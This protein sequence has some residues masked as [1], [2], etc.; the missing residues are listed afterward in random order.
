MTKEL[1]ETI[2]VC[3]EEA[4]NQLAELDTHLHAAYALGYKAEIDKGGAVR[5]EVVK[6]ANLLG[7]IVEA[8]ET[9]LMRKSRKSQLL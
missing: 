7:R 1:I 5:Y 9:Q 8:M 2:K 6:Y 3:R 4:F